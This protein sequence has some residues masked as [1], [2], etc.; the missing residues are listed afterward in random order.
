M[1]II[2]I[3][4]GIVFF[5]HGAQ[6]LLGWFGGPGLRQT[7]RAMDE[8][9]KLPIPLISVVIF[10]EFFGGLGLIVGLLSRVAAGGIGITTLS[11]IVMEHGRHGLFL[12]WFGDR[13][14]RRYECHLLAIAL[15][16]AVVVR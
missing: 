13:E 10:T 3:T 4:L 16:V 8:F 6:R 2:R 9:P 15:A 12:N 7:I 1:T 5:A 14:G 11:A